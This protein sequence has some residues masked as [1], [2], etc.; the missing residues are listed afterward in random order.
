MGRER[1]T[2]LWTATF[3][4]G[5]FQW[6]LNIFKPGDHSVYWMLACSLSVG[7]VIF[8]TLGHVARTGAQLSWKLLVSSGLA[9][10]ALTYYFTVIDYHRGL[11][12]SLYIFHTVFYLFACSFI[13]VKYR[14][15]SSAA[16]IGAAIMYVLFAIA[17]AAAAVSALM[18]GAEYNKY[19]FDIYLV[20]NFISLPTGYIGM[21]L[22]IVFVLAS[23][24]AEKMRIQAITDSLTG[25][26]NR[27]GFYQSANQKLSEQTNKDQYTCLIY[28]DVDKFKVINDTYGHA[29]GDIVLQETVKAVSANIK[30]TDV[31]GRLGGEEFVILLSRTNKTEADMVAERLRQMIAQLSINSAS[32]EPIQVTASFGVAKISQADESVEVAI[33]AADNALYKAKQGGRNMVINAEQ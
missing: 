33:N 16:E 24:M 8:G 31:I 28:W 19:Y 7:T 30:S 32:G 22:F 11:S 17:Q 9:A 12:T 13:L 6:L 5:A 10:I 18:Q 1:H 26:L 23:D 15:P 14:K 29:M 25:I 21:S 2:L 20:I 27:R 3:V 4:I